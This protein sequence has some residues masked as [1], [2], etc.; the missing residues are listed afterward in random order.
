MS[1]VVEK[2]ST[3]RRRRIPC[4]VV[5][6]ITTHRREDGGFV[7][8][9]NVKSRQTFNRNSSDILT[10]FSN[11]AHWNSGSMFLLK[12]TEAYVANY[13]SKVKKR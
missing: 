2:T 11:N 12:K 13:G 5:E 10:A 1:D 6:K 8:D 4:V 3:L 7:I 9:K